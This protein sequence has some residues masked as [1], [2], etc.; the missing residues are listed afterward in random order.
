MRWSRDLP[1]KV[2][3]ADDHTLFLQGLKHILS[4]F[5]EV[6]VEDEALSGIEVINKVRNNKYDVV[7]LDILMPG[8]D[9]I[10]ILK[11]L[12]CMKPELPVLILSM[13]PEELYAIRAL[14]SGA[15]GY[16]TKKCIPYELKEAICTVAQGRRYITS[17]VSE[18]LALDLYDNVNKPLHETLS[19]REYQVM[20]MIASGKTVSQI[21]RE[22]ALNVKTISTYRA[23]ILKKMD[24]KNSAEIMHYAIKHSLI[25]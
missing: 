13:Y 12:K 20:C 5:P 7:L 3:I 6:S 24:M 11:Q 16:L 22:L 8:R 17:S 2:L 1:I 9:G 14:K 23:H 4:E 25:Y 10:D 15:M 21:A 19:D 18:K